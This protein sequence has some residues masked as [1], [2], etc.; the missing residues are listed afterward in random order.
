MWINADY[1]DNTDYALNRHE[2]SDVDKQTGK[3]PGKNFGRFNFN[4]KFLQGGSDQ[5]NARVFFVQRHS[6][7]RPANTGHPSAPSP[8][9]HPQPIP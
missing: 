6:V 4:V 8:F 9:P 1:P 2:K 5:D 7:T 3:G